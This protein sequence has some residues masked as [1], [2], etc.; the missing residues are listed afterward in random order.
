MRYIS[1][2]DGLH[3]RTVQSLFTRYIAG[4]REH[5]RRRYHRGVARLAVRFQQQGLAAF[6]GRRMALG[7]EGRPRV[8]PDLWVGVPAGD[9]RVLWAAVAAEYLAPETS[10]FRGM[11][12]ACRVAL[13]KGGEGIPLL[14]V[15]GT[16]AAAVGSSEL[17]SDLPVLSASD[18][19]FLQGDIQEDM[20]YWQGH[21]VSLSHLL[22][23]PHG[24]DMVQPTG[25]MVEYRPIRPAPLIQGSER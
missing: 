25:Q 20:W 7:P 24:D 6:P 12:N 3:I 21:R 5:R 13:T 8:R 4:D 2:R 1:R 23:L 19:E 15:A 16:A 10:D 17:G 18:R 9:G 11:L 14:V 22:V